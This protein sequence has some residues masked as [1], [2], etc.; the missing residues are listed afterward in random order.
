MAADAIRVGDQVINLQVPG[1]FRVL[2]RHGAFLEIETAQGLRM[3]VSESAV[4]KL[5]DGTP[6]TS[7]DA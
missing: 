1:V 6:P 2:A 5:A 4:R 3:T 7:G